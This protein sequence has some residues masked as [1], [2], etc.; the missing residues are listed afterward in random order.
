MG[1]IMLP[2]LGLLWRLNAVTTLAALVL[3][4]RWGGLH[5]PGFGDEGEGEGEALRIRCSI[6]CDRVLILPLSMASQ[7]VEVK[8][9]A[10]EWPH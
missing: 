2:P 5:G 9:P 8:S 4:G 10:G 7:L 1:V 6:C 3:C